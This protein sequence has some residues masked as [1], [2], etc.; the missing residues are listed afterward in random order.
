MCFSQFIFGRYSRQ[1][2]NIEKR[3]RLSTSQSDT[4]PANFPKRRIPPEKMLDF[5]HVDGFVP[6]VG[7]PIT[8]VGLEERTTDR[9]CL[10]FFA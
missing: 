10:G 7:Y 6:T 4:F 5:I 8:G 2:K 1:T 9:L 3:N